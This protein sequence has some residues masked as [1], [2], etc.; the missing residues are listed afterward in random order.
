[1]LWTS[2]AST[3]R[4]PPRGENESGSKKEMTLPLEID[5]RDE[6]AQEIVAEHA[7]DLDLLELSQEASRPGNEMAVC[8]ESSIPADR[9]APARAS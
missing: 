5:S 1:M 8:S 3:I 9:R 4:S 6:T 2:G 7:A